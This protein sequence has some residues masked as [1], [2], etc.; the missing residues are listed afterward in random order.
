[1]NDQNP[2]VDSN[3]KKRMLESFVVFADI[4]G[5]KKRIRSAYEQGS[6]IGLLNQFCEAVESTYQLLQDNYDYP[7]KPCAIWQFKSFT[8]NI[9][10]GFP[11]EH[12]EDRS[13]IKSLGEAEL[14]D[15]LDMLSV[16]QLTMIQHGFFVRGGISLGKVYMDSQTVFGNAFINAYEVESQKA[17]YPRIVLDSSPRTDPANESYFKRNFAS[18]K[19]GI[20]PN[21]W[22]DPSATDLVEI[23]SS[24][25]NPGFRPPN[26]RCLLK[27][28]DN[29]VFLNYLQV[30]VSENPHDGPD[31]VSYDLLA[32][33][34]DIV[35]ANLSKT[36]DMPS[37]RCKYE[38]V[39]RYHNFFCDQSQLLY[40]TARYKIDDALLKPK[41]PTIEEAK[42]RRSQTGED[43]S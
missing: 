33:H 6:E 15:V 3:G 22:R 40:N 25:Y 4:L 28:T 13:S 34:R 29:Q 24:A 39:A 2:Y 18:G 37:I 20:A 30:I 14:G 42:E 11:I 1:M 35:I 43:S 23:H 12:C 17:I 7:G 19:G 9:V 36:A 38:W 8:D 16:F 21:E 10:I 31:L 27:D 5:Y 26:S 32:K 41:P